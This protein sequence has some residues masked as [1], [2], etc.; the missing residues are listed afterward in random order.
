MESLHF[1]KPLVGGFEQL[2]THVAKRI[3]ER[4]NDVMNTDDVE[5]QVNAFIYKPLKILRAFTVYYHFNA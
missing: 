3:V 5:K 2:F 4:C 1:R